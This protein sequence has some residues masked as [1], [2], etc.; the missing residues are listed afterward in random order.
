MSSRSV[1]SRVG[2]TYPRVRGELVRFT[3]VVVTLET[4][5]RGDRFWLL[6]ERKF[7]GRK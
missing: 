7:S 3:W 6:K 5:G 4:V 2:S 1:F